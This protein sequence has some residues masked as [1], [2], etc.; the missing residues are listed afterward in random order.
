MRSA[1]AFAAICFGLLVATAFAEPVQA[2]PRTDRPRLI[3][4]T[5]IGPKLDPDD[6][7]SMVRL[8]LYSDQFEIEGLIASSAGMNW[9]EGAVHPH[10]IEERIHAYARVRPRLLHHSPSYPPARSLLRAVKRG[11]PASGLR[12]VGP[13]KD[14]PGSNWIIEV[15]D[16]PDPRP[17][18]IAVWGGPNVLAQALWKVRRTRS[19][20]E[21]DRFV[22]KLRVYCHLDQ[23]DSAP[24]LRAEFPRLLYIGTPD[25]Y[26]ATTWYWNKLWYA[27]TLG[28]RYTKA[29]AFGLSND[30]PG[31]PLEVVSDAWVAE[32]VQSHGPLGALYP[33]TRFALDVD[34][35]SFLYLIPNGLGDPERPSWGSWG[36]RF[37]LRDGVFQDAPDSVTGVDGRR[38]TSN[39]ATL[40]RWR[41]DIQ[42]DFAAR[43]DWSVTTHANHPPVAALRREHERTLRVGETIELDASESS[44]R[45]GNPLDFEWIHYP[46]AGAFRG[47]LRIHSTGSAS[48][49]VEVRS[50]DEPGDAHVILRLRDRGAPPLARYFRVRIDV[51]D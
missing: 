20:E 24:W 25:G 28:S 38:H 11:L 41:E 3:V 10:Y 47:E 43:M 42:N 50:V 17:V 22:S 1:S 32:R 27:V 21:V 34:S 9:N 19:T 31:A 45:D 15:V 29:T 51:E 46:E 6:G 18:W 33:S 48:T 14:S 8:L 2:V 35:V 26:T 37:E 5:D 13:G 40:W 7:Q 44:D 16:R 12:A 36:G 39:Y 4:L 30:D 49:R 23:D